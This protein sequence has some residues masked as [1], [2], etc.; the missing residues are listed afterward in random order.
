MFL[1]GTVPQGEMICARDE[2]VYWPLVISF[3]ETLRL[4]LEKTMLSNHLAVK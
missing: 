1:A 2:A 4:W 3:K